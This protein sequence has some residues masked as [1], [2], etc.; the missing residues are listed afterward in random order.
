MSDN[1]LDLIFRDTP[2]VVPS[3]IGSS[4]GTSDHC[5]AS[6]TIK[7]EHAVPD[8]SFSRKT[9][10]KSQADW[11]GILY[12]LHEFDWADIYGQADFVASMNDVFE[13]IIVSRIPS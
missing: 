9:Y 3:N 13:I 11:D 5:Y 2:C 12:D 4:T 10:L 6:A 7:T 8:I 1:C